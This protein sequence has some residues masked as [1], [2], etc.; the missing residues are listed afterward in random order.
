MDV[1]SGMV[2]PGL[3]VSAG[4]S[5]MAFIAASSFHDWHFLQ[6]LVAT[7]DMAAFP[8]RQNGRLKYCASNQVGDAALLYASVLGPLW[9]S[10][11]E[12]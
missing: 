4:S 2:V 3:G 12:P 1:D 8:S 6:A 7:L 11:R 5:G 9:E 10:I